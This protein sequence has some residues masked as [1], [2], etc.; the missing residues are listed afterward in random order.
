MAA[1]FI[2]PA[3]WHSEDFADE[4]VGHTVK[5]QH[6][7]ARGSVTLVPD[8]VAAFRPTTDTALAASVERPEPL[9]AR[10]PE[11]RHTHVTEDPKPR[12]DVNLWHIAGILLVL[13]SPLPWLLALNFEVRAGGWCVASATCLVIG[14]VLLAIGMRSQPR[15]S[16]SR[17]LLRR[18]EQLGDPTGLS[19]DQ[20]VETL[21]T[22]NGRREAGPEEVHY[23]WSAK[24]YRLTVRCV[25]DVCTGIVE[26][27]QEVD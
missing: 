21:G 25:R 22:P 4:W 14:A 26:E 23:T 8:A 15:V 17:R 19:R 10:Q 20:L 27:F 6:C 16:R 7:H 18:R 2:C 11:P 24:R 5:C 9:P 12:T 3:C 1:K 13:V